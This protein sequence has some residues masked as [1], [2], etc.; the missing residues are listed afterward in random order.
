MVTSTS[1]RACLLLLVSA[2]VSAAFAF[3]TFGCDGVP[4]SLEVTAFVIGGKNRVLDKFIQQRPVVIASGKL[5]LPQ[6]GAAAIRWLP[7]R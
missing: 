5:F 6:P 7:Y 3:T 2:A 4:E 1:V